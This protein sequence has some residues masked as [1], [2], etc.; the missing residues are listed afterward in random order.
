MEHVKK[1]LIIPFVLLCMS[2]Q[3]QPGW[4]WGE[5]IDLAKEKNALYVDMLKAG[6]YLEAIPPHNWLL[7]NTP[8]LNESLYQNGAK[9]YESLAETEKDEVKLAEYQAKAMDMYDLRIKYFGNEAYVLNRKVFP[10][11]KYYKGDKSRYKE[12]L[13]MFNKAFELNGTDFY[14][15]NLAAYMDVVR[16]YKLTGGEISDEEVITVYSNI[17]DVLDARMSENPGQT[18]KIAAT[19][20]Q[21]FT[22]TIDLT[23]ERVE[24][25][26]GPK[27]EQ[28]P[29]VKLAKKIFQ[30]M[31]TGKCTD[32]PL[33]FDAAKVVNENE[34]SFGIAKFLGIR[35]AQDGDLATALSFYNQA[36]E[37][38]DENI[39]KAE[40]HMNIARLEATKG[41]KVAARSSAK[42]SYAL[43]PS[44]KEAYSLIGHLYMGSFDECKRGEQ[45]TMDY[46]LF[47]AA[48][49]MF[50]IAG[51]SE[52]MAKAKALFPSIEDI[53][54][55]GYKEGQ[56]LQV[57]CWIN[58]TVTLERRP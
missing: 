25:I 19:I 17:T 30:L 45:K 6:R 50:S 26:F 16:R 34:P 55:D 36:I 54:S 40:I 51:D 13:D 35:A 46:A 33:A 41:N 48:H 10:A 5:Q 23:C 53:F 14:T 52:N 38:T 29:D 11:Y 37:L 8:D 57:G 4:N 20:E 22:G 7:E 49:K 43:D 2:L 32:R 27:F 9:I 24:N 15:A 28:S 42:M 31:L 39:K 1:A 44:N 21:M 12:L 3:A 58:E 47:I 56:T 18:E